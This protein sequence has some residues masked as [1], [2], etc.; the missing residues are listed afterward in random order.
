MKLSIIH[1]SDIHINGN[2]DTILGRLDRLKAACISELPSDGCVVIAISGDIAFSGKKEQYELARRL[3][4]AIQEHIIKQKGSDVHVVMVPGNHDCDFDS[5]DSVRKVL[6]S[7]VDYKI[8]DRKYYE[9]ISS[10]QSEYRSFAEG[11]GICQTE[12]LPRYEVQLD[13]SK[14][15]FVLVN[16]SWMSVKVENP[17]RIVMPNSL[18]EPIDA[19]N[20]KVVC[21]L[22][23]HPTN[24]LNP[25]HNRAF[26]ETIR[27]SADMVL[28]GHEHVRDEYTISG[29]EY[30][31]FSLHAKELQDS[32]SPESAF[33]VINFDSAF[34]NYEIIDFSWN[35]NK[36][37]EIE[38]KE[39]N[40]H[41][42]SHSNHS[43][44][45]PNEK[46]IDAINDFGTVVNHFAKEDILLSDLY[47]WPDLNKRA[48]NDEKKGFTRIRNVYEELMKNSLNIIVG[49]WN[50]GKTS[51][52]KKL[53]L[54]EKGKDRCCL[55]MNGVDFTSAEES[56]IKED[57]EKAFVEQYSSEFIDDFR[58]LEKENRMII[59][60][61]YDAIKSIKNRRAQLLDY[62]CGY[63]GSVTIILSSS[64]EITTLLPSRIS[65]L[66][67][68]VYYEILPFGNFKR[69]QLIR[70][71]YQLGD[72]EI[73][74][75]D[76]DER[77]NKAIT[78]IDGLLG[79]SASIIP[80]SPIFIISFLQD[81]D[82]SHPAYKRSQY[83][84]LY[85]SL[86]LASLHSTPG[87]VIE[88]GDVNI[89]FSILS[90]LA[91]KML[92]EKTRSFSYDQLKE[93]TT[94][95]EENRL[96]K[97]SA[98]SMLKSMLDS[99][100]IQQNDARGNG[101]R[102]KYPYIFYYFCGRYIASKID[103]PDVKTQI[104]LMSKRLHIETYGNVLIFACHFANKREITDEILLNA[105]CTLDK[106]QEF[107]FGN[108]NPVFERIKTVVNK[109]VPSV[110]A[111]SDL[112]AE[113]NRDKKLIARDE[114]GYVDGRIEDSSDTIN[115]ES[116]EWE[117]D[118]AATMAALKTMEVLGQILQNYPG[119]IEREDKLT[120]I[121]EIHKL[122]MR[123]VQTIIDAMVR[124]ESDITEYIVE[125]EMKRDKNLLRSDIVNSAHNF[126]S[127]LLAG[128]A[129]GMLHHVAASISNPQLLPAAEKT[130]KEDSSISAKLIYLDLKMNCLGR[131]DFE[132]IKNLSDL[133]EKNNERFAS[134]ILDSIVGSFLNYKDCDYRLRQKLC[135]LC[136][137][138][139]DKVLIA[140]K[141]NLLS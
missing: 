10:V 17:G 40:Y 73:E 83:G 9:T 117:E 49:N 136:G 19:N 39:R 4:S 29:D 109:L 127:L 95:F 125:M 7:S 108:S 131:A 45:F 113:A 33:S 46:T 20:Y 68:I 91:F 55:L 107:D 12:I 104:E 123:A 92:K 58:Q 82:A 75:H 98:D 137:F 26:L 23:H 32:N 110:V 121:S 61:D 6:A 5:E 97:V 60:D 72:Q 11:Y 111:S 67:Q 63:F 116:D 43:V 16:S 100:I 88:Q 65:S 120:I 119:E 57:I 79:K 70:K 27:S 115:D 80:A 105:Y 124:S 35:G 13:D 51:I 130:F 3:I 25:D 132:E 128:M 41:K 94:F 69:K 141:R 8:I 36:Y 86:I 96:I 89:Y 103:E 66:E 47:V 112:E 42:N 87:V 76:L 99:K 85:E 90:M 37:I 30:C 133:L 84:Y 118:L 24:W 64:I 52:A 44:Y 50:S 62:I 102:F 106:Y 22:M 77:V 122:G 114:Q 2:G 38:R 138:S 126:I 34:Q 139:N 78:M 15:L 56:K 134:K 1:L 129:R 18:F 74:A 59:I 31:L 93:V 48:F 140:S 71:W 135:T 54:M 14:A 81:G 53:F 101:Y 28:F 21:Y